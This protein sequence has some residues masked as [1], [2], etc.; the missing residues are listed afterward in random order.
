M[1]KAIDHIVILVKDLAQ[2]SADYAALGFTVIPGGEHTGGATHNSL[3]AFA[4]GSYLELIAFKREAPEHRWWQYTLSHGEGL[5]DFALLPTDI[6][7]DLLAARQR[8]LEIEGPFPGGRER[9]DGQ[10][11]K[12]QTG[13]PLTPDLPFLCAD[14]TPRELRVPSGDAWVHPNGVTAIARLGVVTHDL[15]A[16]IEHYNALLGFEPTQD[17]NGVVYKLGTANLTLYSQ[18]AMLIGPLS[19]TLRSNT[20]IEF[21]RSLTH[22]V[23]LLNSVVTG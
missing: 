22:K 21:D 13:A 20:P 1:I 7:N 8:G 6:E 14:V 16:S 18:K 10:Q 15:P 12:W 11:I 2:A 19:L 17:E 9:P 4:D 5:I 3:V 23:P